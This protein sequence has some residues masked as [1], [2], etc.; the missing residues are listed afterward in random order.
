MENFDFTS[1]L[2]LTLIALFLTGALLRVRRYERMTFLNTLWLF[3][4]G[5]AGQAAALG[6]S[7][8]TSRAPPAR[9]TP[10]SASSP[11]SR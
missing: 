8:S 5:I 3:L 11:R 2:W 4:I 9:C 7:R 6:I 1:L 10:S